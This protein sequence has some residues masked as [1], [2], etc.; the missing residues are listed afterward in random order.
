MR[1]GNNVEKRQATYKLLQRYMSA[2]DAAQL[3]NSGIVQGYAYLQDKGWHWGRDKEQWRQNPPRKDHKNSHDVVW[4]HASV[5]MRVLANNSQATQEDLSAAMSLIGYE[6]IGMN[7]ENILQ[8][9]E[10]KYVRILVRYQRR[11]NNG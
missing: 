3:M 10:Y 11:A 6:L 7:E 8:N 1:R 5:V 9:S 4:E 2:D